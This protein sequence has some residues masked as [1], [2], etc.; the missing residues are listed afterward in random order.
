MSVRTVFE[1]VVLYKLAGHAEFAPAVQRFDELEREKA[2]I[3]YDRECSR[4]KAFNGTERSFTTH[5]GGE[6]TGQVVGACVEL[7]R[8]RANREGWRS[9]RKIVDEDTEKGDPGQRSVFG[10]DR[11]AKAEVSA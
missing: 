8:F 7:W 9:E 10:F 11:A 1:L 3:A 2:N 5:G 6:I 4:A